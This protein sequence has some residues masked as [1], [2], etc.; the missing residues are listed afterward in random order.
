[1]RFH[2]CPFAGLSLLLSF[3]AAC[4]TRAPLAAESNASFRLSDG[5]RAVVAADGFDHPLFL[6]SAPGDARLFV[7]EQPGRVRWIEGGKA[8]AGVFLDM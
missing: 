5:M 6:C 1:V 4:C 3:A 8:S 2:S 7:V